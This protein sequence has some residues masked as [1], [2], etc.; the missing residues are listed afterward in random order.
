MLRETPA[1]TVAA[2]CLN[3]YGAASIS[4]L[5]VKFDCSV[6]RHSRTRVAEIAC[7]LVEVLLNLLY[8]HHSSCNTGLTC[9]VDIVRSAVPK[10]GR[11]GHFRKISLL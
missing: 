9:S 8:G 10:N 5:F 7:N 1:C 2:N 4:A 6:A 3:Q 11:L